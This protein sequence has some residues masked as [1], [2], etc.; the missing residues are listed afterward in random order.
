VILFDN[1]DY[2]QRAHYEDQRERARIPAFLLES[3]II[4]AFVGVGILYFYKRRKN[5]STRGK[6][7]QKSRI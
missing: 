1:D 4:G 7:T 6:Q 2:C 3:M 5:A